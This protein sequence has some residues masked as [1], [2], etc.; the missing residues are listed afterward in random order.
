MKTTIWITAVSVILIATIIGSIFYFGTLTNPTQLDPLIVDNLKALTDGQITF[1]VTGNDYESSII[2]GVVINGEQYSWS[3]GSQENSTILKGETKQWRIDIGTIN[4]DNEIQIVI[5]ADAGSVSTNATVGASPTNTSTP[6]DSNYIYDFYGG[7][8]LINEGIHVVATSQ[9]P[10][11]LIGEY[12]NINDFWEMLLENETT[13]ATNQEFISIILSRGDKTSGGYTI[14]I[15]NFGWLESYPVKFLFQVNF[16]DPGDGVATTDALTNPLVLVPIGK[17]TTGEY[18]IEVPITQYIFNIDHKGTQSYTQKLTFAPVFWEQRLTIHTEPK[19][20]GFG[21]FLKENDQLVISQN[22]IIVYNSSSYEIIL[23]D[24]GTKRIENQ[25]L[26]VPTD[27]TPIVLRI[28]NN[29]IYHGWFWSP[30]SSLSSSEVIIQTLVID[31]TIQI[32]LG[33]P[34]SHFQGEDPRNN[35]TLLNYFKSIGKLAD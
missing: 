28:N 3:N 1:N 4:K 10:R 8:D 26:S 27:G 15:E 34:Q 31:K 22:H 16:T 9:D 7:V 33:Y 25:S 20:Q 2:N 11:T 13:Q 6:T 12:N 35:S 30:T 32:A 19:T 29:D 5:E 24:E 21:I 17:L 14:Q 23:T 18:N